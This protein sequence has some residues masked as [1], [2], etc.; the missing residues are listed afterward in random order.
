MNALMAAPSVAHIE[1]HSKHTAGGHTG[2][3]AWFCAASQAEQAAHVSLSGTFHF[4][5]LFKLPPAR[6]KTQSLY[7]F[8]FQRGPP[9][10]L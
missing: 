4:V 5:S 8:S 2:F 7:F 10:V 1:H 9:T 6:I 3:C